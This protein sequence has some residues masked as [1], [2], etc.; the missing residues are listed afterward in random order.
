MTAERLTRVSRGWPALIAL[1]GLLEVAWRLAGLPASTLMGPMLA[2]IILAGRGAELRLPS[3]LFLFSQGLVG[4]MMARGVPLTVFERLGSS[5][6]LFLGGTLWAMAASLL[7]GGLLAYRRVLPG[8]TAL[9]GVSPGAAS[10]MVLMSEDYGA[11]MRLVALMQYLRVILVSLGAALAAGLAAGRGGGTG[12]PELTVWFP[13]LHRPA[14][15]GTILMTGAAVFLG[16]RFRIPGGA[17]LTPFICGLAFSWAGWLR[18][19]LPPW[20]MV[21]A[22][23]LVGWS[24]GLRFTRAALKNAA[25]ALPKILAALLSL[26]ALCALFAG[27]LVWAGGFDPLTAYLAASPG[28][29]D[30]VAIIAAST[31]ADL[32]FVMAMQTCRMLLV[33]FVGPPLTRLITR[34][35]MKRGF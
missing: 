32:P 26:L 23:A 13:A 2:G 35:L 6:P 7:I 15:A 12:G 25:R 20:L 1:S 5:W 18:L 34:Q 10:A 33:L 22:Y 21:G 29:V 19:E 9:W 16:R 3:A 24:I 28:G 27:L 31:G 4:A 30:T 14:F 11:D 8:T 17:I